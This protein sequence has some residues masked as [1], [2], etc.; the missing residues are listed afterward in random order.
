MSI[1]KKLIFVLLRQVSTWWAKRRVASYGPGFTV[2][3]PCFFNAH[4]RIGI[5]CHFNGMTVVG[6]GTLEIGDHFHSGS[7][8]LVL[9][10][11]HNY[12][13]NRALP[14]DEI[15]IER[16]V[17]IGECVWMGSRVIVLPG[18]EIGDGAIVQAGSVVHGTVPK[19]AIVGGNPAKI[20]R[21]RDAEEFDRLR[22][23]QRFV[24]WA[25]S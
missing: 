6:I 4:T 18:A 2:N 8:I 3:Y 14:Y 24:G 20:I 9:T 17:R 5:D 12:R 22:L 1:F 10:A 13:S 19:C 23:E 16:P 7:G 15:D 21:Y 25:A 11:N